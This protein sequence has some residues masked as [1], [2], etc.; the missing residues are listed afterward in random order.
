MS[1]IPNLICN[2]E[3]NGKH[4]APLHAHNLLKNYW[5]TA[6]HLQKTPMGTFKFL[7]VVQTDYYAF[8]VAPEAG[9]HLAWWLDYYADSEER[10]ELK[11]YRRTVNDAMRSFI[12]DVVVGDLA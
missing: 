9:S 7:A 3:I 12:S 10:V 8:E 1:N 5:L 2:S 11:I 6:Y 4:H